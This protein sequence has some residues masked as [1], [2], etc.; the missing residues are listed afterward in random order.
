MSRSRPLRPIIV[1]EDDAT[2]LFLLRRQLE[3]A[4]V[5]NPLV[6]LEDG[7]VTIAYLRNLCAPAK[8]ESEPRPCLLFLDIKMPKAGGFEVLTWI[9]K[10]PALKDLEVVL[11]SGA[12]EPKD[13]RR[14]ND[15]GVETFLVKFPAPAIFADLVA[16]ANNGD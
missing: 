12:K 14:A 11:L 10:Q 5:K 7:E 1:A 2:D 15:L 8:K 9:R 16:R 4:G 13:I 3:K 6:V